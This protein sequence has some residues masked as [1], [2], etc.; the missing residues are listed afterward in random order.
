MGNKLGYHKIG[1]EIMQEYISQKVLIINT[2][3]SSKQDCLI[4]GTI[5]YQEEESYVNSLLSDDKKVKIVVYGMNYLDKSV[6][7]KTEQ[8]IELGFTNI[9]IYVGGLFEWLLLQDIYG[10]DNFPTIGEELELLKFKPSLSD[11]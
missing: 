4:A 8:L 5:S 1:F 7:K 9:F 3:D 6:I 11:N 2:L 10:R